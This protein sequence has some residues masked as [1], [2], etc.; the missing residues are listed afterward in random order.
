MDEKK[1]DKLVQQYRDRQKS[2]AKP[3]ER[4]KNDPAFAPRGNGVPTIERGSID[5]DI[6]TVYR[7]GTDTPQGYYSQSQLNNNMSGPDAN[8]IYQATHDQRMRE[9]WNDNNPNYVSQIN[10]LLGRELGRPLVIEYPDFGLFDRN[11]PVEEL[12]NDELYDPDKYSSYI[13][14]N[15]RYFPENTPGGEALNEGYRMLG[16]KPNTSRQELT[17]EGNYG[18]YVTGADSIRIPGSAQR[19]REGIGSF[20]GILDY[21][22]APGSKQNMY[23]ELIEDLMK[24]YGSR[25]GSII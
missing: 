23:S 18:A 19:L 10:D 2:E 11:T 14:Y 12:F 3:K 1:F 8:A 22:L 4:E 7:V 24:Y 20:E 16:Q 21:F 17:P 15:D 5:P 13:G 9:T 6:D 25:M